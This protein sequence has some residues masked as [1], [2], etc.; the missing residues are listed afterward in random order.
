M[1]QVGVDLAVLGRNFGLRSRSTG[2]FDNPFDRLRDKAQDKAQ[3]KAQGSFRASS[4]DA[5][6]LARENSMRSPWACQGWVGRL[7]GVLFL[8]GWFLLLDHEGAGGL[9]AAA[10]FGEGGVDAGRDG[11]FGVGALGGGRRPTAQCSP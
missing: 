8:L 9:G 5:P 11:H 2:P 7:A 10:A 4:E 1:G 3:S 6:E